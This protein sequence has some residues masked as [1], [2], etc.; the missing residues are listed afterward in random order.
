VT[1]GILP[2]GVFYASFRD[3]LMIHVECAHAALSHAAAVIG[4]FESDRCPAGPE[5]LPGCH[6]EALETEKVVVLGGRP[7]LGGIGCIGCIRMHGEKF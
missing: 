4:E 2:V 7:G 5:L 1:F 6:G 3:L